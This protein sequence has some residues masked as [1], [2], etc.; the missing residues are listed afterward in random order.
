MTYKRLKIY[1]YIL[2]ALLCLLVGITACVQ[3]PP[4]SDNPGAGGGKASQI[5]SKS[6]RSSLA[7]HSAKE[8]YSAI[9]R[10]G[11]LWDPIRSHLQLTAREENQPAVQ[12]QIQWFVDNPVY[13]KD[14]VNNASPYMYYVYTQVRQRNLPTELVL[15]PII[16]SGYDPLAS[17]SSS[18][19]TGLWQ[20]MSS[21]AHAYGVHQTKTFD[22]RRDIYSSTNAALDYLNY[23]NS[24]FGGDWLLA[25]A[26][27][28]AGEGNVQD[29]IR[30]NTRHDKNTQF[31]ALPLALETRSYIP[32]LLAL[33]AIVK[34]P[35]KYGVT[36]PPIS[37]TP[38]LQW[39][40][41]GKAGM[42]LARAAQLADVNLSE[43]QELN[44]GVKSSSTTLHSPLALPID[45][46]ALYEKKLT[47][48]NSGNGLA[49]KQSLKQGEGDSHVQLVVNKT[50]SVPNPT[51]V[52]TPNDTKSKT[53]LVKRG[54]TLSGIARRYNVSI[55]ELRHWNQLSD[56]YLKPG[57]KLKIMLS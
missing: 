39:V 26:A 8:L 50:S 54:D 52:V 16:E 22:G 51:K 36:L 43:L 13:L 7:P 55:H 14:A 29:A 4:L 11:S 3:F 28:D 48:L 24:F 23:L 19:A 49:L 31:W 6:P 15:L 41:I 57:E 42:S 25:I 9:E 10:G 45:K 34:N 20:L 18:G 46:V 12:K 44:P 27:Y 38:C 56:D 2:I 17:N 53:Y 21:T 47:A 5:M 30:Q 35:A 32:R 1:T 37:A 33:A 40:D